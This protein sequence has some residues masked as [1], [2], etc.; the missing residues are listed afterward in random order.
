[1]RHRSS[2]SLN[3]PPTPSQHQT[4]LM[5]TAN[6][7]GIAPPPPRQL[8]WDPNRADAPMRRVTGPTGNRMVDRRPSL[9]NIAMDEMQNSFRQVRGRLSATVR[10]HPNPDPNPNSG[11]DHV[12]P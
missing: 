6:L 8:D 1:M 4:A 2:L 3:A 10:A 5:R 12:K 11:P 7:I 9:G